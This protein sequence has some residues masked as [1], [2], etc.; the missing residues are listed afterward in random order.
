MQL[1]DNRIFLVALRV[2][3][4]GKNSQRFNFVENTLIQLIDSLDLENVVIP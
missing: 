4:G 2:F 1:S 3:C